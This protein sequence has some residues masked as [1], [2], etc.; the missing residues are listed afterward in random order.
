MIEAILGLTSDD[1]TTEQMV[2]RSVLAY[3]YLLVLLRLLGD[4][5]FSGQHAAID[6]ILSIILGATL[7]RAINGATSFIST[8]AVGFVLVFL[9]RVFAAV[10][11]YFPKIP[12][13]IKGRA[14]PLIKNGARIERNFK[15]SH[16]T[17]AEVSSTLRSKGFSG[18]VDSIEEAFLETNGNLSLKLKEHE[19]I[20]VEVLNEPDVRTIQIHL[21]V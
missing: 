3:C 13:L 4:R 20:S 18:D 12:L 6:I 14:L 8:L 19:L 16:V 9:H 1:L 15:S 7:S 2:I 5:R 17:Q 10:A 11:Y 21:K